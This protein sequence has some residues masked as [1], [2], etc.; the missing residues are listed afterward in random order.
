VVHPSGE[1]LLSP[2]GG[3][4]PLSQPRKAAVSDT[5]GNLGDDNLGDDNLGDDAASEQHPLR[6]P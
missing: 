6:S 5:F 3:D 4:D 1:A 2:G